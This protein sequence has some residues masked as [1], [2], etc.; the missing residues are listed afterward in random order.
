MMSNSQGY[1]ATLVA[2]LPNHRIKL[3]QTIPGIG[4][5]NASALVATIG[6]ARQFKSGRDLAAWIGLTPLN[7]S[8]GGKERLGRISRMGD[9]Y[10]RQLLVVGMSA[11]VRAARTRPERVDP[12]TASVLERKPTRLA[13]VAMANKT[14]RIIWAVLTKNEPYKPRAA[15]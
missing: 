1:K 12:W 6:D 3:L 10:L 11:R 15:A 8:S 14:A 13:T 2:H 9:R 5:V 4:P 7:K